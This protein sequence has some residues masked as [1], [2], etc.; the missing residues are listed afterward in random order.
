L[1][2]QQQ[3]RIFKKT[4]KFPKSDSI[5]AKDAYSKRIMSR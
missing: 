3:L 2:N 5:Y 1:I 4:K